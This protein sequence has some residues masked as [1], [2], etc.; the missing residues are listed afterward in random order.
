VRSVVGW[1]VGVEDD[2]DLMSLEWMSWMGRGW[3]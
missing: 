3:S 1:V 2:D